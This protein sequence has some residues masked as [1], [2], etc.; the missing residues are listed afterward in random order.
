[1]HKRD[2]IIA[3]IKRCA[4]RLGRAPSQAEFRRASKIS[5]H[6]VYKHFRGMR[7]AVRAAGL[8]P[9]PR[10]SA[11]DVNALTVDWARVVRKLGRLPSRA[12]YCEHGIH[13]AGTLHARIVWSQM[14]HKFVLLVKEFHLEREWADVVKIVVGKFPL[15]GE[16]PQ[17]TQR[18][19]EESTAAADWRRETQIGEVGRELTRIDTNENWEPQSAQRNT[20]AGELECNLGPSLA[21]K[22]PLVQDDGLRRGDLAPRDLDRSG[23]RLGKVVA[24]ALAIEI[25][26]AAVGS[27]QPLAVSNQPEESNWQLANSNWQEQGKDQNPDQKS[28]STAGRLSFDEIRVAQGRL[29]NTEEA[30]GLVD[31]HGACVAG[32]APCGRPVV[33]GEPLGLAAMAHAPTNEL[34]VLFLFGIVA[35]DLGF[36]VERLQAAFPDCEAKREVA[37]GKWE[38][39]FIELEIYSRNFKA[40]RHDPR[41]CHVIVCWKHNWPDC[42]EWLEVIELSK[43]VK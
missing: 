30:E 23:M 7:Q 8:E 40:H 32:Q 5:W 27:S 20:E 17:R 22:A 16:L 33:Y 13:H 19:T 43:V 31:K 29:Q 15:L 26:M 41:G 2:E 3:A 10:G 37:P 38:L 42:P 9:G 1:M 6:Q 25:L 24:A 12:E 28:Q 34:G 14:A 39:V 11:L 18:T 36:R 35:A 4:E 21:V